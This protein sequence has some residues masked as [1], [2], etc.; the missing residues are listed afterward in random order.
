MLNPKAY[1]PIAGRGV[2][3]HSIRP[4]TLHW[5]DGTA[6]EVVPT[7]GGGCAIYIK[8]DGVEYSA[9]ITEAANLPYAY[10]LLREVASQ[11]GH[12]EPLADDQSTPACRSCGRVGEAVRPI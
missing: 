9:Q 7:E 3:A 2:T 12:V 1:Q 5:E 8:R 6:G 10:D 4:V 11:I